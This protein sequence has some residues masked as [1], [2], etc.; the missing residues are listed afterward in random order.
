MLALVATLATGCGLVT[1]TGP[2]ASSPTATAAAGTSAAGSSEMAG[3][4]AN[5]GAPASPSGAAVD[6]SVG[7]LV[8]LVNRA[9]DLGVWTTDLAGGNVR[10]YLAHLDEA[11]VSL[12]DARLV[13]DDV[14]FIREAPA[15]SSSELWIVP[16]GAAPPRVLLDGVVSFVVR[17]DHEVLAVRDD[18]GSREIWR[19]P[20]SGPPPSVVAKVPMQPD[21]GPFG[22]AISPDGRTVAAGWVGGP[23]EVVGPNPA[24][25]FDRGAPLVVADGGHVVAVTGRAGEAYV[26]DGDRL[27]DLAPPDSDPVSIPG[28]GFVAWPSVGDDGTLVGVEVHD[29]LAGT[30]QT[31]EAS[32]PATNVREL[33]ASLVVLEATAFD[34]LHR[35]VGV[36]DL[37]DG[38]FATFEA[39]A[40]AGN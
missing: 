25:F 29:L 14:A 21:P 4:S 35:T 39:P 27:T 32:G 40:P 28:T 24:S 34:P 1:P 38:R 15:A 37:R 16:G 30:G 33:T 36:L 23:L 26:V 7:Q 19:V 11:G 9:G 12:R 5:A 8:W 6:P 20:T 22:F 17:G 31:Y 18:S 2:V 3:P 13:G 10:T